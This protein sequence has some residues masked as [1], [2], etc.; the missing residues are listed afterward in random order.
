MN[1]LNDKG[2]QVLEL[3]SRIT[4]NP[5]EGRKL[6]YNVRDFLYDRDYMSYDKILN[7]LLQRRDM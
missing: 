6:L 1:N 3:L 7:S 2:I 4:M 5:D